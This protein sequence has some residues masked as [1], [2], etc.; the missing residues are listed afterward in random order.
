MKFKKPFL[1]LKRATLSD[2]PAFLIQAIW[3]FKPNQIVHEW[4]KI[5]FHQNFASSNEVSHNNI[6]INVNRNISES[7]NNSLP[8]YDLFAFLWQTFIVESERFEI[9]LLTWHFPCGV[10]CITP[11]DFYKFRMLFYDTEFR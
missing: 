10:R 4:I 5:N 9:H 2:E 1:F 11:S 6:N 8:Q 3:L 7:V